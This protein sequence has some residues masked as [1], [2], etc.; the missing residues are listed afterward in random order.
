MAILPLSRF[1]KLVALALP[2]DRSMRQQHI[3]FM[4]ANADSESARN[5]TNE[6]EMRD[7]FNTQRLGMYL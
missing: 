3:R 1:A 4:G 6:D 2:N 5:I 7:H